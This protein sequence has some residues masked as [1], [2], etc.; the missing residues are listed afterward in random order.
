[1]RYR[2]LYVEKMLETGRG[3]L[4]A[5]DRAVLDSMDGGTTLSSNRE[6]SISDDLTFG[7]AMADRVA[8]FGGRCLLSLSLSWRSADGSR[9][10]PAALQAY[11]LIP[12]PSSFSIS[13]SP[14][15]LHFRP[16]SE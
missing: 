5:M 4:S 11:S 14:A 13:C 3:E 9:R 6:Q 10:I 7:D 2:R 8:R 15:S 1:M 12:T 16:R